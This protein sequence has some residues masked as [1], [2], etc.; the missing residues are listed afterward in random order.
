MG[1]PWRPRRPL[2]LP[3]PSVVTPD[4]APPDSKEELICSNKMRARAAAAGGTSCRWLNG[5]DNYDLLPKEN[6]ED[7]GLAATG[8]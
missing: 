2:L 7:H 6:D 5:D 4:D 1:S 8:F 3:F